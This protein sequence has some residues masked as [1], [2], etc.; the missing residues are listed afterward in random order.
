MKKNRQTTP[1]NLIFTA[2]ELFKKID[3]SYKN[4]N[5]TYSDLN[6]AFENGILGNYGEYYEIS[7]CDFLTWLQKYLSSDEY[8]S[9]IANSNSLLKTLPQSAT[10]T[11][12]EILS[13]EIKRIVT[14]FE[15]YKATKQLS[16]IE[17]INCMDYDF[18]ANHNLLK[19][20]NETKQIAFG[21]AK[22]IIEK[23]KKEKHGVL[24]KDYITAL[25]A[26]KRYETECIYIAKTNL[27]RQYFDKIIEEGKSDI[28]IQ[29][30]KEV[31][32]EMQK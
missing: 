19:N 1:D 21:K 9:K 27:L 25:T 14:N 6:A 29:K 28:F 17:K 18:L 10:I 7:F 24:L 3:K 5:L 15:Q 13:Q 32:M 8:L 22:E 4:F 16:I 23:R 2:C 31:K 11:D 12:S 20:S 26:P 30:V